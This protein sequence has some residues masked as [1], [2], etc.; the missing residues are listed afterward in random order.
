MMVEECM[1]KREIGEEDGNRMQNMSGYEKS[2][3]RL[4]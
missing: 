1:R 3:V 4:A 2:E